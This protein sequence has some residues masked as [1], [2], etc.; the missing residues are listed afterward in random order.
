[1]NRIITWDEIDCMINFIV[2]RLKKKKFSGVY[3]VPKG[4]LIPAVMLCHKLNL[5][6][7]AA[8]ANNCIVVD[9]I[10]DTGKTMDSFGNYNNKKIY[11]VVLIV[12][13]ERKKDV[14]LYSQVI[15]EWI[16]FPWEE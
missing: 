3:G 11:K 9:D 13:G 7:L 8:P 15:D 1:M 10:C 4:G 2:N 16:V 6:L 14:D 12:R 5:P